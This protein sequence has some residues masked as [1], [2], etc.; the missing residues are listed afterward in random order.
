[1][2][3]KE[4]I[5]SVREFQRDDKGLIVDDREYHEFM[6]D[7]VKVRF[8]FPNP[9]Q[10]GIMLSLG[11]RNMGLE[12]FGTFMSFF[13]ALMDH[14]TQRY[15]KDRMLDTNDTMSDLN[16]PGGIIDIFEYLTQEVWAGIPTKGPSDY[17]QSQRS[18]GNTSTGKPARRA[19]TTS[20]SPRR[21]SS[22]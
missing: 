18:T 12:N 19:S 3:V 11:G 2:V 9:G 14:E 13:F 10:L 1:M 21:A 16:E 17:R 5:T 8:A 15:F 7:D 20:A 4:F 22:R 6:H